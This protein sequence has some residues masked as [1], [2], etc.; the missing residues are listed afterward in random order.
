[1]NLYEG[2]GGN[3]C[4]T[5][6]LTYLC[7]CCLIILISSITIIIIISPHLTHHSSLKVSAAGIQQAWYPIWFP[8]PH[9]LCQEPYKSLLQTNQHQLTFVAPECVSTCSLWQSFPHA[10]SFHRLCFGLQTLFLLIICIFFFSILYKANLP[11]EEEKWN[12]T[13]PCPRHSHPN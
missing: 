5:P 1:M 6:G 2:E 3:I 12:M 11:R 8:L 13:D 10:T 9:N 4:W 7:F